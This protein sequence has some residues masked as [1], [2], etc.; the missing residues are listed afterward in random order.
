[1]ELIRTYKAIGDCDLCGV[2]SRILSNGMMYICDGCNKVLNRSIL[3]IPIF[4]DTNNI[5]PVKLNIREPTAKI[6]EFSKIINYPSSDNKSIQLKSKKINLKFIGCSTCSSF[7]K[8]INL[9]DVLYY[10]C[11]KCGPALGNLKFFKVDKYYEVSFC[12]GNHSECEYCRGTLIGEKIFT[13][14]F[15][16]LTLDEI[17]F[18][19]IWS[20]ERNRKHPTNPHTGRL[21]DKNAIR[22]RFNELED[23][24]FRIIFRLHY[25]AYAPYYADIS[26]CLQIS[27]NAKSWSPE[28]Y[29]T[30]ID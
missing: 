12:Q 20:Y 19:F 30:Y 8:L 7:Y 14:M 5:S 1:M 4:C 22:G 3:D 24:Y 17:K 10:S 26:K 18:V 28:M 2:F 11:V 6:E 21:L 9:D 23:D 25:C 15:K 16:I 29:L 13:S 27:I